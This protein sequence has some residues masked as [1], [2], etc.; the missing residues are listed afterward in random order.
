LVGEGEEILGAADNFLLLLDQRQFEWISRQL[1]GIDVGLAD[2]VR[3]NTPT[4]IAAPRAI[5]AWIQELRVKR[6][7]TA[8]SDQI[9]GINSWLF[10]PDKSQSCQQAQGCSY[11]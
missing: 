6:R 5:E 7:R 9:A 8:D 10:S 3:L 1:L 2:T 4:V 11:D